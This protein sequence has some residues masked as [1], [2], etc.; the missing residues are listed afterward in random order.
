MTGATELDA[1]CGKLL[2]RDPAA[3]YGSAREV[4]E[5]LG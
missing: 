4:L 3:P 5:A 1:I 2:A